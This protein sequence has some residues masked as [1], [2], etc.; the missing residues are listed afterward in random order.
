MTTHTVSQPALQDSLS[1]T[2]MEQ[3]SLWQILGIWL[4]G[5]APM[6]ILAWLVFPAVSRD[7]HAADA[8]LLLMKLLMMG[9]IWQF[10]LSMIVL[11]REEGNLRLSTIR[12]RFWL[13]NPVSPKTGQKNYRLW[14]LLIPLMLLNVALELGLAPPLNEI[15]IRLFPLLAEPQSRS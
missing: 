11:Y 15:W 2:R 8:G 13:N 7:L 5:G 4:A 6:W 3:Y 1:R 9:L 14:W 10:V 12:R